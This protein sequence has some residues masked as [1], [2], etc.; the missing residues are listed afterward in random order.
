MV[1][2]MGTVTI[3]TEVE[4]DVCDFIDAISDME[5]IAEMIER[6]LKIKPD[7]CCGDDELKS[8][9]DESAMILRKDGRADLALRLDELRKKI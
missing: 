3:E 2:S 4:I 8:A 6:E 1:S 9:L 5:L 7:R